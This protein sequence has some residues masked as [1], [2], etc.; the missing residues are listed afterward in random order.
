MTHPASPALI[1]SQA[2][3]SALLDSLFAAPAV[4]V[5]TESNSLYAYY[6][7]ICLIQLSTRDADYIVD[8]LAELDLSPLGELFADPTIQKVFH[9]AEQDVAGLK[10]D[11]GFRF[12]DLFDTMW[13][14]RILGWPHVG[15]ADVLQET[16]GVRTNKRYQRYNWGKRPLEPAALAYAR[17]DTHYLLPL[18]DLQAE[19]LERMGRAE[20]AYE[21]FARLTKTPP[22]TVPFGPEA[23]WRVK[24]GRDLTERE[25]AVLWE[26]YRW[27]DRV[28][29][30]RNCPPFRVIGDRTLVAIA[31]VQPRTVE[32]LSEIRGLT[33]RLVHRYGRALLAAV[34]RGEAG[35]V[36]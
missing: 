33:R 11:F 23:F 35:P 31:Q 15:L 25:R 2:G 12:A 14:A 28:A 1:A 34:A 24:G 4:A 3:L 32:A 17:L 30:E 18:R 6:E 19:A 9:A 20:E 27:R 7:R 10:R 29:R 36:P 26:L 16:F 8:P 13:A 21:V 22:A 5:D